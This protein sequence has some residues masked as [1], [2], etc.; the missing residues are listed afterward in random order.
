[1]RRANKIL[2]ATVAV[3]L[4]LVL[5]STSIV[6]GVFA[7]FAITKKAETTVKLERFGVEIKLTPDPNLVGYIQEDLTV[8]KGDSVS[9]TL[10]GVDMAI[11]DSFLQALKVEIGGEPTV[12]VEL[13]IACHVNYDDSE[14]GS[15]WVTSD[16]SKANSDLLFMP[17][18][19][20]MDWAAN[21]AS[22]TTY[23]CHQYHNKNSNELEEIIVRN[24][25]NKLYGKSYDA[26]KCPYVDFDTNTD[27]YFTK[28]YGAK[29]PISG[30]ENEF[31]LGFNWPHKYSN[32]STTNWDY[33]AIA[34][35]ISEKASAA[36]SRITFAY[37]FSIVQVS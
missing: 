3:L 31:Y 30:V 24:I 15:Y 22:G 25:Y 2:M 1:M 20:T 33:D 35:H 23:I 27:Y 13:K 10:S 11:G 17:L 37:T 19:F 36:N 12:P 28:S 18:G 34:T 5:I 6:S 14:D 26:N 9:I 8:N 29:L 7:R 4:C 16:I 32:S 21:T